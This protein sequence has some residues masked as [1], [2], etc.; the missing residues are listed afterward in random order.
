[1]SNLSFHNV[2]TQNHIV[3]SVVTPETAEVVQ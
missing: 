1:M 3:R 2:A